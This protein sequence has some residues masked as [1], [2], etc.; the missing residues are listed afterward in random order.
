M[1]GDVEQVGDSIW[2]AWTM[3]VRALYLIGLITGEEAERI[4]AMLWK[5]RIK[6][7]LWNKRTQHIGFIMLASCAAYLLVLGEAGMA[8]SMTIGYVVAQH[9]TNLSSKKRLYKAHKNL[10]V[11]IRALD[12][13]IRLR[14]REIRLS[15]GNSQRKSKTDMELSVEDEDLLIK[16]YERGE[17]DFQTVTNFDGQRVL[18]YLIPIPRPIMSPEIAATLAEI[19]ASQGIEPEPEPEPSFGRAIPSGRIES[20]DPPTKLTECKRQLK[21]TTAFADNT[22]QQEQSQC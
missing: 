9:L 8:A 13:E 6:A 17:V 10:L 5:E 11:E 3:P 7:M 16:L 4:K 2:P 1:E 15:D 18:S 21:H 22:D 20:T 12:R 19:K 14:D